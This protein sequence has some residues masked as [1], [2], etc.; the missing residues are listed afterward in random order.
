MHGEE[1]RSIG[2]GGTS[3]CARRSSPCPWANASIIICDGPGGFTAEKYQL[4]INGRF[5][6]AETGETRATI[7]PATEEPIAL[8]P[9]ATRGDARRAI[10]AARTSFDSRVWS[11]IDVK[12]RAK[13]LMKIVEK[14][15]QRQDE[16]AR[17]EGADAIISVGDGSVIDTAKG[18]AIPTT[19]GTGSEVTYVAVVKDHEKKQK[20]LFGD[21][22]II[23]DVAILDPELPVGLPPFLTAATGLDAFSHGLEAQSS[24]QREPI[25]DAFGLHAI[26]HV[27]GARRGMHH[28]TANAIATPH[29]IRFNNDV[30]ADRC[31]LAAEAMGIDVRGMSDEAAGIRA[32]WS[33]TL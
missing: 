15:G 1:R 18:I 31:R 20:L 13:I 21:Y 30:V 16:L 10:E 28:G 33:G 29:V 7:N 27:I 9:V 19:A 6:D 24:A 12:D 4:Y 3:G 22:H 14:L 11:G 23:P 17:I 25:A 5:V 32:A 2:P 26:A 8:V